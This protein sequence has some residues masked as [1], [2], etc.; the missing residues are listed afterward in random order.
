M[1]ASSEHEFVQNKSCSLSLM[2]M[3]Q[4]CMRHLRAAQSLV[5]PSANTSA[6]MQSVYQRFAG[7]QG[8]GGQGTGTGAAGPTAPVFGI[9]A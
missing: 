4:V 2:R 9:K 7:G 1:H 6:L 8:A 3:L 5:V